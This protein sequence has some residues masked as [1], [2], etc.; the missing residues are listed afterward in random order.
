MKTIIFLIICPVIMSSCVTYEASV[1]KTES[2]EYGAVRAYPEWKYKKTGKWIFPVVGAA[3]GAAYGYNSDMIEGIEKQEHNALAWGAVGILG[4]A[5]LGNMIIRNSE[6]V[7]DVKI[8]EAQ[9][10]VNKYNK[11]THKDYLLHDIEQNENFILI[12]ATLKE[13]LDNIKR[14]YNIIASTLKSDRDISWNQLVEYKQVVDNDYTY[15]LSNET[16]E[17]ANA[18]SERESGAA[19][20]ELKS[21]LQSE[22]A[23][24]MTYSSLNSLA[25]F[26]NQHQ[27]LYS[28]LTQNQKSQIQGEVTQQSE[29]ILA[30]LMKKESKT[31]DDITTALSSK[32]ELEV[33]HKGFDQRYGS[34]KKYHS[35]QAVYDAIT[36]KK[37][38][39]ISAN[40]ETITQR[41]EQVTSISQLNNL[42]GLYL[43]QVNSTAEINRLKAKVK[44]KESELI[45][46]ERR[47]EIARQ[48]KMK[49]V[50]EETMDGFTTDGLV[51]SELMKNFFLGNFIE[52]PFNRDNIFFSTMISAYM[53]AY[54]NACKSS[55]PSN[56]VP[57]MENKCNAWMITR[58]GYGVEISRYC[59]DWVKKPTGYYASPELYAAY[60]EI[61]RIQAGDVFKNIGKIIFGENPIGSV[62]SNV[63]DAITLKSDMSRL[64]SVNGCNNAGLKRFEENLIRFAHNNHPIRLTENGTSLTITPAA[65]DYSQEQDL[66][67]LMKDLV[68]ENSKNWT[69]KYINNSVRNVRVIS[70]DS[71]DRPVKIIATYTYEGFSGRT[72]D[73]VHLTFENGLPDCIYF[74]RYSINCRTPDR[75]VVADFVNGKYIVK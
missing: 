9:K 23:K 71:Q 64:I 29:K 31:I 6:G 43:S 1:K 66:V 5:L 63:L 42:N 69:F 53:Y 24:P 14:E 32:N 52:I 73:E 65:V 38:R 11:D 10:W 67:K 72:N 44:S 47:R 37:T 51:N 48:E 45:E 30:E 50:I 16:S 22:F 17:L 58:N 21:R 70:R 19:Y 57:I 26:T 41:I 13:E 18:I 2:L 28:K 39:I 25:G 54:A 60:S 20:N 56:M 12:P 75:R 36:D 8:S 59:T 74:P 49:R 7:R 61:E 4:G 33:F 3:A 40:S 34:F 62:T 15:F 27:E 46:A 35:V 68:Y 55:L